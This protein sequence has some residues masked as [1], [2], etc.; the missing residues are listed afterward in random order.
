MNDMR[1]RFAALLANQ[2]AAVASTSRV[3]SFGPASS[4]R[5]MSVRTLLLVIPPEATAALS[6]GSAVLDLVRTDL[7]PP[8][9]LAFL[10]EIPVVRPVTRGV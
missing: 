5:R 7:T 10:L 2:S 4:F 3:F 6:P 9:H 8:R 1:Y